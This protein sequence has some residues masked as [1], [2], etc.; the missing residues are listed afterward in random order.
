MKKNEVAGTAGQTEPGSDQLKRKLKKDGG[1]Q[2]GDIFLRLHRAISWL[3]AAEEHA[4]ND[5]IKF[6]SL[7]I[8]FNS[9]YAID[10]S[11]ELRTGKGISEKYNI[12]SFLKVLVSLDHDQKIF[13]L[14]WNRFSSEIRLILDNQFLFEEF[15]E[16]KRGE[17][18][19]FTKEL[20][21]SIEKANQLLAKRDVAQLL[22][23]ILH[24]LYVLRNQIFHGGA[25]YK[26]RVNRTQVK[27]V[28]RILSRLVPVVIEI[29]IENKDNDW[30]KAYFPVVN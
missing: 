28:V 11:M 13:G 9:C 14:L 19:D 7:W 16:Y 17:R 1:F 30:G 15:W 5:D 10:N 6:I 21:A 12:Y 18:K 3:K 27:D 26:G 4:D 20:A 25:T 8:S 29:M 23:I 24:R 22:E 2:E